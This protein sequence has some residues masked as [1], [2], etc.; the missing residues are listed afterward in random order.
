MIDLLETLSRDECIRLLRTTSLGRVGVKI[1][2]M[3]AVLP[4]NYAL[5]GDDVVFRS[6]PGTKLSAAVLGTIIAFEADAA[7]PH[8]ESG[9]SVLMVGH[10]SEITDDST[11]EE[12]RGLPLRPWAGGN[13]DHFVRLAAEHVTGRRI[14]PVPS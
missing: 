7:D 13:R 14:G 4:V 2:A 9:W 1:G 11:L 8:D 6:A 3:P 5:L 10:A 12:A